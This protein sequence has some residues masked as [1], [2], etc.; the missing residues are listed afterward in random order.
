MPDALAALLSSTDVGDDLISVD[1]DSL[2]AIR[3]AFAPDV[4]FDDFELVFLLHSAAADSS[5][6]PFALRVGHWRIDLKARVLQSTIATAV[7]AAVIA[8]DGATSVPFLVLAAVLPFLVDIERVELQ[9]RD[10]IV[11]ARLKGLKL[12]ADAEL[13][14]RQIPE[15]LRE[16]LTVFEFADIWDRL[17]AAGK[18][19]P[20]GGLSGSLQLRI[21][22]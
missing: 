22:D 8:T 3:D 4:P 13:A 14:F 20:T 6:E 2:A 5:V 9:G 7:L 11:L 18:L 17:R 16:Q 15:D 12:D 19:E 10:R 1:R 21:R